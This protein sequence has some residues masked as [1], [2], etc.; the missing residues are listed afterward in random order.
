[1]AGTQAIEGEGVSRG[2]VLNVPPEL[3]EYD[4]ESTH[5]LYETDRKRV[6]VIDEELVLSI[7]AIGVKDAVHVQVEK[8]RLTD[9]GASG[10]HTKRYL[11]VDGRRRVFNAQEANRRLRKANEPEVTVPVFVEKGDEDKLSEIMVALNELRKPHSVLA[12]AEKAAKMLDRVKDVGRVARAFGVEPQTINVWVKLAGMSSFAKKL[13][14]TGTLKPSAIVKFADLPAAEQREALEKFL[15]DAEA[16]GVKPTAVLAGATT[17]GAKTGKGKSEA[18]LAPPKRV[19]RTILDTDELRTKLDPLVVKTIK[20]L[21]GEAEPKT[22]GGLTGILEKLE[23][24]R[25]EKVA[26]KKTRAKEREKRKAEAATA[27]ASVAQGSA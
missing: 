13:A 26:A 9:R 4:V 1:M 27:R 8:T 3:L 10:E 18:G 25:R 21:Y 7:M 15:A 24:E 11:V 5:A 19:V 22:I 17:K 2:V 20:W 6:E 16:S 12:K 23:E 14:D